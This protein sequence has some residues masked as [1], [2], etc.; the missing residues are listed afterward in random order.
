MFDSSYGTV[1]LT[2]TKELKIININAIII[3][4]AIAFVESVAMEIS[5]QKRWIKYGR[6]LLSVSL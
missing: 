4:L 5:S 3:T 2:L 1:Q 6:L